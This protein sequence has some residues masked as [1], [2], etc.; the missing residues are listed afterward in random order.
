A[1]PSDWVFRTQTPDYGLDIMVEVF[2]AG[3]T[4]GLEFG[5]Q[6]RG[7]NRI[8][9]ICNNQFVTAKIETE[10]LIDHLE[11]RRYPV[12]IFR[13]D[14]K[15]QTVYWECLQTH[16]SQKLKKNWRNSKEVTIRIPTSQT[17]C[18][19]DA[20]EQTLHDAVSFVNDLHPGSV[21]AA[22]RRR[23][24]EIA[25]LDDR[26]TATWNVSG[27]QILCH[28]TPKERIALGLTLDASEA[29]VLDEFL[30]RGKTAE[31]TATVTGSK[32][33]DG[34]SKVT[35]FKKPNTSFSA[36]AVGLRK[37][38][39]SVFFTFP[40]TV[41]TGG[42][43]ELHLS[44]DEACPFSVESTFS[45]N[46]E[47]SISCKW[48]L[49]IWDDCPVLDLPYFSDITSFVGEIAT[50]DAVQF[51]IRHPNSEIR[52]DVT[53]LPAGH[54]DSLISAL[55]TI[56][57]SREI[58]H[59]HSVNP[60]LILDS[61]ER[62]IDE[63][64]GLTFLGDECDCKSFILPV[65]IFPIKTAILDSLPEA[66]VMRG[67]KQEFKS[68]KYDFFGCPIAFE[69]VV[70]LYR[71]VQLVVVDHKESAQSVNPGETLVRPE[72]GPMTR[73]KRLDEW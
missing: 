12:F 48:S 46:S 6:V 14:N 55:N 28:V 50:C 37:N 42:T 31:F 73:V 41:M 60:P 38:R 33:L 52:T 65:G 11:K 29:S 68:L 57:K 30:K 70:I 56:R 21:A 32:V 17:L 62:T 4:S 44:S 67:M 24:A 26:L 8:K 7:T 64:H 19:L 36:Q 3:R 53:Q 25:S 72:V 58:A 59:H 35:L 71:N 1:K 23:T 47:C 45:R 18:Q 2:S 63:L 69:N 43:E 20:F 5:V 54:F 27:E 49:E 15:S 51:V 10:N 34:T 61:D 22:I 9:T 40:G 13:V 39:P 66:G 16:A